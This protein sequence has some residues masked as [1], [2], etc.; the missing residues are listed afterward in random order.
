MGCLDYL[1]RMLTINKVITPRASGLTNKKSKRGNYLPIDYGAFDKYSKRQGGETIERNIQW[2]RMWFTYLKLALELEQKKIPV[3]NKLLR[4]NKTAY[5]QWDLNTILTTTFDKWW[6]LH[7]HLFVLE[8]VKIVKEI[9]GKKDY[10]YLQ[11]PTNRNE[12]ELFREIQEQLKGKL[13]G[14]VAKFPFSN[15]GIPYLSLHYQYNSLVMNINGKTGTQILEW[16]NDKY[17]KELLGY[18]QSVSRVLVKGRKTLEK[19]CTLV[20]P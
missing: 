20:F 6:K 13:T 11:I 5:K 8:Q 4:V 16:V 2:Y 15:S 9:E 1:L 12:Q 18:E 17:G 3:N 10:L 14:D 19:V 7:R